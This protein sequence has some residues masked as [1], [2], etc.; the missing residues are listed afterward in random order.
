MMSKLFEQR[1]ESNYGKW[2]LFYGIAGLT[3]ATI[4]I[5]SLHGM[6]W[7]FLNIFV[8]CLTDVMMIVLHELGH[9][10]AAFLMGMEVVEIVIGSGKTIFELQL[11][12]VACKIKQVPDSGLMYSLGKSAHLYRSREFVISLCGP[13]T[14][15]ILLCLALQLPKELVFGNL[16]GTHVSPGIMF[17]LA[18]SRIFIMSMFPSRVNIDGMRLSND[19]LN[20]LK[21]P[22]MSKWDVAENVA[23]SWIIDGRKW[24]SQSNHEKAIESFSKAIQN[25]PSCV[26][27]YQDRG[28]AYRA[29]KNDRQ[30]L[31]NYQQAIDSLDLIT[32]PS[33]RNAS[34]FFSRAMIYYEWMKIDRTKSDN[35]IKHLTA[36]IEI[37]SSN[38]QFYYHRAAIYCSLGCQ[39][40]S[41]ED[42]TKIIQLFPTAESYYNR[43]VTYYQVKDYQSALNDF[44]SAINLNGRDIAAYYARGNAKY[45]LQDK[46]DAFKDYNQAKILSLTETIDSRD[47]HGFYARGIAFIR[48]GDLYRNKAIQDF[49]VA[50]SLCIENGNT[51][52]LQQ[53][54]EVIEAMSEMIEVDAITITSH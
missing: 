27:A 7:S 50:E 28:N 40:Q 38:S 16:P 47:E 36:A 1:A 32:K 6:G 45:E 51:S 8:L 41:I 9:A 52:L 15:F 35:T 5:Q 18:N 25:N 43:G 46:L 42:F 17:C 23:T 37:D 33:Y 2:I 29:M 48:L 34:Y 19:G 22:F 53:V 39:M 49:R 13:L 54:R 30:A 12:S 10:V 20:M 21:I 44:D 31:S 4:P 26:L 11:F 24:C 14:N 3:F